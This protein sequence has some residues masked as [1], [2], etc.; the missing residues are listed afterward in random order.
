[1]PFE[2]LHKGRQKVIVPIKGEWL[3]DHRDGKTARRR[4]VE[5]HCGD[6]AALPCRMVKRG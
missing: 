3:G 4:S 1:V 5:I 6:A 2:V